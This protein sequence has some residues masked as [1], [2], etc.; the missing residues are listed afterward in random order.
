MGYVVAGKIMSLVC[1]FVLVKLFINLN[2]LHVIDKSIGWFLFEHI[3]EEYGVSAGKFFLINEDF[4]SLIKNFL[5]LARNIILFSF[6]KTLLEFFFIFLLLALY[7]FLF[8]YLLYL[9]PM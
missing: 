5:L 4:R 8:F 7:F 3:Y 1:Y 9:L 2:E 6:F